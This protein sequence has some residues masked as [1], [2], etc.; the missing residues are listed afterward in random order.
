MVMPLEQASCWP[1]S[2]RGAGLIVGDLVKDPSPFGFVDAEGGA[3]EEGRPLEM[4]YE[5]EQFGLAGMRCYPSH[6]PFL[7]CYVS[8]T[9]YLDTRL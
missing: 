9:H 6:S 3:G 8:Y 4:G 1:K 5:L 7:C 2:G